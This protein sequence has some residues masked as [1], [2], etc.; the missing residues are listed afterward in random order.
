MP[1]SLVAVLA[2]EVAV[3]SLTA[4]NFL[5]IANAAEVVRLGI[6]LGLLSVAIT[7]VIVTGGIDLSIGSMLGL[8]AVV[9]GAAY[10]DWHFSIAGAIATSLAVG[11]AGGALN[12]L[13]V[14]GLRVP[15]LIVTL[16]TLSLF[17]GIAEGMTHAA[18]NYSGFPDGFLRFGQGDLWGVIPAQ[19][20]IFALVF[21]AYTVLLHRSVV[22]R[23]LY[24]IGLAPVGAQY[25]GLPVTR[26]LAL[27]YVLSGL[28]ASLAAI[29]YV[30]HLGQARADAGMGYELD[31]ITAVVLGGASVFG[32]RGTLWGTLAGLAAIV[33]LQNGL[34]LAALPSELTG[35]LTGML[36]VV[37]I[38]GERLRGSPRPSSAHAVKEDTAVKN[39]QV[40]VICASVLVGA[41]VVAVTNVWL[42]RSLTS[43]GDRSNVASS[44]GAPRR[45]VIGMMPKAKGD[46]YFVSCRAGAEEAARELGVDLIWDG[47]TSLDAARQNEIVESWITRKVDVIAAAVENRAGISTVLR[48]ARARGIRVLTW[49]ADAEPDARDFFVNQATAEGIGTTLTDE[50]ARLLGGR[51]AFAVITGALSAANQNEWIAFIRKRLAE[52]YPH[53]ELATIRPSDDDRDK[54]FAEAQLIMKVFPNVKLIMAISAPAVPGAAEAVRQAGR[55]EVA[56][57]GLSL[58]NINKPYVHAGEVQTV[59]L[60]DTRN[61]GYLTVTASSLAAQGNLSPGT[62]TFQAGRLGAIQLRGSEIVLGAPLMFT[63]ANIDRFDF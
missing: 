40:A 33:V 62:R 3:F 43:T 11:C 9:L 48:K 35:V 30:A 38:L 42:V 29:V 57:I 47:P 54:A 32:G 8:A 27:V 15:P 51:G 53:L 44:S 58:P 13:L 46:P 31:A 49:D 37:T 2:L 52:K 50:A 14:A 21:A 19:M 28:I 22:G 6:E 23:A 39:S 56:I 25:A 7:P 45:L 4:Q 12:A 26:R 60:W 36:L 24:A 10:R 17:R 18:V 34:H 1:K 55:K 63:K 20:P 5:S 41:A 59:V 16:G 61:L